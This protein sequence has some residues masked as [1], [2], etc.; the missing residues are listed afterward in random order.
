MCDN[1]CWGRMRPLT[2][3]RCCL[4]CLAP[5]FGRYRS[6]THRTHWRD[7][8]E[9]VIKNVSGMAFK[10]GTFRLKKHKR[11]SKLCHRSCRNI[12]S[13]ELRQTLTVAKNSQ[14]EGLDGFGL[15]SCEFTDRNQWTAGCDRVEV[16]HRW[17]DKR[18]DWVKWKVWSWQKLKKKTESSPLCL[19]C[20]RE[21]RC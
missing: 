20:D 12:S 18:C 13:M 6:Q 9:T 3:S 19:F 1:I 21:Q 10:V 8:L 4:T 15:G 11:R 7:G 14:A 17:L 5:S 2:K 16:D